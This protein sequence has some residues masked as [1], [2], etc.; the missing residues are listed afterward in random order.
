MKKVKTYTYITIFVGIVLVLSVLSFKPG[1]DIEASFFAKYEF[2]NLNGA[3]SNLLCLPQ[4]NDVIK[5]NNDYLLTTMPYIPDDRIRWYVDQTEKLSSYLKKRGSNL[6][7]SVTPYTSGKYDPQL[8]E[9]VYDYGNDNM[10]RFVQLMREAN[11]DTIDFREKMHE[12]GIDHYEMMYRTDHHW[13]TEAGLYA[14]GVLEKYIIEKTGCVVDERISDIRNYDIKKYEKWHLGSRGQRTGIYYAGIDDFDLIVPKFE[15]SIQ[16]EAGEIGTMPE[17]VINMDPFESTDY[18]SRNTYDS[19]MRGSLGNFTNTNSPNDIRILVISDSMGEVV[20]PYLIMGFHQFYH[21]H[22]K[23][24][25]EVT[26]ELIERYD[27]D[28][29]ILIYYPGCFAMEDFSFGGF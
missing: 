7:F 23:N 20:N 24:S 5:L 26:P 15:T 11:V 12:D 17:M 19:V 1:A 10:D 13:T 3:I 14:Y 21:I 27:P 22:N 18:F 28:V 8:P 9:G 16:N 25:I 2:V 4:V 29:V 6:V